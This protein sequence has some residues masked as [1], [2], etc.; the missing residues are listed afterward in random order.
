MRIASLV[1]HPNLLLF[2]G[3]VTIGN[4]QIVTEV[5]E[6]SLR[7]LMEKTSPQL[8]KMLPVLS[9]T[10]TLVLIPLSIM[11]SVV[12]MFSSTANKVDEWPNWETLGQPTSSL[13]PTHKSRE[14]SSTLHLKHVIHPLVPKAPR[15]TPTAM[16][17]SSL[18]CAFADFPILKSSAVLSVKCPSGPNPNSPSGNW[19]SSA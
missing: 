6:T 4:L 15:W 13:R 18:R 16:V 11:T 5:M 10:F 7:K 12:L 3:A 17:F 19:P 1:R 14:L 8:L 2:M 9:T